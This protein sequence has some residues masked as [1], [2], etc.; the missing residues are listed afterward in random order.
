MEWYISW[1]VSVGALGATAG[2]EAGSAMAVDRFM[3]RAITGG[4]AP[5]ATG[6]SEGGGGPSEK[7]RFYPKK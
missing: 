4:I 7:W 2:T 6:G 1:I 3:N 5:I